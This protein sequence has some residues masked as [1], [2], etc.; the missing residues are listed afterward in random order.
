M[1]LLIT[2]ASA[3]AC[4]YAEMLSAV[5]GANLGV[6]L[7][8]VSGQTVA[9][10]SHSTSMRPKVADCCVVAA[11]FGHDKGGW[12]SLGWERGGGK[13]GPGDRSHTVLTWHS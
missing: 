13:T 4:L 10:S 8:G 6:L 11:K 2:K 5:P 3:S 1:P 9:C 7:G 12:M